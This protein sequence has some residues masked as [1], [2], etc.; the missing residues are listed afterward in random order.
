MI[1]PQHARS[2]ALQAHLVLETRSG[3]RL[4]LY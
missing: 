2:R 3:F 1:N 4:I